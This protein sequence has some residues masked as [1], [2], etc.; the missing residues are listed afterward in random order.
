M[1]DPDLINVFS[2]LPEIL[3]RKVLGIFA[4]AEFALAYLHFFIFDLIA[5]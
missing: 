3:E 5:L 4:N 1:G 2:L